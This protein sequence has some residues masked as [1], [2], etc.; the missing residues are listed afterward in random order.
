TVHAWL[1]AR[2]AS[3]ETLAAVEKRLAA[4]DTVARAEAMRADAP[5]AAAPSGVSPDAHAVK[6]QLIAAWKETLRADRIDYLSAVSELAREL[7]GDGLAV[8]DDA[9][10]AA[11]KAATGAP[12]LGLAR[13]LNDR[14]SHQI[15]RGCYGESTQRDL[16]RARDLATAVEPDG[17]W[18]K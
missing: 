3:A 7:A 9:V 10:D 6:R 1:K 12:Q 4:L 14:A 15:W 5:P 13:L 17:Y 16:E 11:T 2:Y 8:L 18:R